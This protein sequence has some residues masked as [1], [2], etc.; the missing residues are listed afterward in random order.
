MIFQ[1]PSISTDSPSCGKKRANPVE[2]S[3]FVRK[4]KWLILLCVLS[5]FF[6]FAGFGSDGD[7]EDDSA[8]PQ[9]L[10]EYSAALRTELEQ[11]LSR[12]AGVGKCSVLITF[13]DDGERVYALDE[14]RSGT[15]SERYE[16]VLVS[17][18]SE[19]LILKIHTPSVRGVA[20]ICEGGDST[21]VKND[22]TEVLSH[23]LGLSADRIS[24]KK[25]G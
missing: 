25:L 5:V 15:D 6:L 13:T 19:G 2:I 21:R 14:E 18:R 7:A 11:T 9:P 8:S 17:S 12:M 20:V 16:Y 22:V 23:T 24:V 4:N 1:K 10:S 3:L